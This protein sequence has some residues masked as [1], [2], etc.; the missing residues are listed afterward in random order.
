SQIRW[1]NCARSNESFRQFVRSR[2]CTATIYRRSSK[3]R[4][5][6]AREKPEKTSCRDSLEAYSRRR[7]RNEVLHPSSAGFFGI[8]RLCADARRAEKFFRGTISL[9]TTS[10]LT[11]REGGPDWKTPL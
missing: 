2:S 1:M 4:T 8:P 5:S 7:T 11:A 10:I 3:R 6:T 9:W